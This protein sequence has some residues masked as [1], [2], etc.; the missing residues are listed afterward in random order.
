MTLLWT[1]SYG[2]DIVRYNSTVGRFRSWIL[3][4]LKDKWDSL[5]TYMPQNRDFMNKLSQFQGSI[6]IQCA[7]QDKFF[8]PL[9][10]IRAAYT[11]PYNNYKI[12]IGSMDGHGSDVDDNEIEAQSIV[13]DDW[14]NY[15]LKD[16]NNNVMNPSQKFTY[17]STSQ[18][19]QFGSWS[20]TRQNSPTW[21]PGANHRLKLYLHPNGKL[22]NYVNT[23]TPDTISFWNDVKDPNLTMLQAVN[24]EFTGSE[25]SSKFGKI[26]K[27]FETDPIHVDY[28]MVGTP[29]LS[30]HYNAGADICQYNFQ[31]FEVRPDNSSK[32]VTRINFTNR[33]NPPNTYMAKY[34]EAIPHGH[35]F[36]QGNRIRIVATNLDNLT[37]G[38]DDFLKTNPHV[39][40]VLKRSRNI[41][42]MSQSRATYIE[43]PLEVVP[44]GIKGSSNEI[45][46]AFKLYQNYPNP[47]NPLTVITYDLPSVSN[48]SLIIYDINGKIVEKLVDRI[49]V[50]GKYEVQWYASQ[51]SSGMYFARLTTGNNSQ[52][53]KLLLVK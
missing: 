51:V 46:I 41:I 1:V 26:S 33:D 20:F 44:I 42:Y 25:F 43:L 29:V 52:T 16:E 5:K 38:S 24:W 14:Y 31:I 13:T 9:G 53:I 11:L 23:L 4:A 49:Q 35:I 47:F 27:V 10:V 19:I 6:L 8:T 3:S 48:V 30:L 12:Y 18:P 22:R 17:A 7:W 15:W 45:P 36:K 32:L 28:K 40:P 37:D 21:P 34:L 2:T 50:S 39:L